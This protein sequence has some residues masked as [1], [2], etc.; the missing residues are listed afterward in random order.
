MSVMAKWYYRA[1]WMVKAENL[2]LT[3]N[4]DGSWTH[5]RLVYVSRRFFSSVRI[6]LFKSLPTLD[7]GSMSR[8]SM[9]WGI[10]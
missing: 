6:S 9:Y 7:F 5:V 3:P 4:I 2:S 8:N 1:Q 10:L